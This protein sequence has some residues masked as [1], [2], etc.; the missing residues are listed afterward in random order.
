MPFYL[1][2]SVQHRIFLAGIFAGIFR[3]RHSICMQKSFLDRVFRRDFFLLLE[4]HNLEKGYGIQKLFS[5]DKLE[6]G[7]HDRIGLVGDN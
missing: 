5:I 1:F 4:A 2:C 6:I 3:Y 7:E